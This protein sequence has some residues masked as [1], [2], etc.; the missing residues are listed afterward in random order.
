M[1][2]RDLPVCVFDAYGTLFDV[3]SAV[4]AH[5]ATVG[6][7]ADAVSA[8]WRQKQIEYS[9]LRSLMGAH[10][11]FW[12][13]TQDALDYAMQTHGISGGALRGQLLSAYR[14]LR[15]YPDAPACLQALRDRGRRLGILSNGSPDMLADAVSSAGLDG[16][17]EAVLSVE[18]VGV[19]KTHPRVYALVPERFNVAPQNVCFVSSN[20][21]DVAGAAHFGF[22]VVWINRLSQPPENLPGRAMAEISSLAELPALF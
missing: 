5:R 17:F 3:H 21:W 12:Q 14:T 7:K 8:L 16:M 19:F 1:L 15:A 11:D 20:A 6:A 9:W 2:S 13:L 18:S 22:Q 10:A 4:A